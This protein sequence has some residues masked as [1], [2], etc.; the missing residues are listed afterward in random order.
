MA[1]Y[2][3]FQISNKPIDKEGCITPEDYEYG[4]VDGGYSDFMDYVDDELDD[5]ETEKAVGECQKLLEETFSSNGRE[6]TFLGADEFIEEWVLEMKKQLDE[7]DPKEPV[8]FWKLQKM[9]TQTHHCIFSRFVWSEVNDD[10]VCS[11]YPEEL[12]DFILMISKRLKPGDKVYIGGI[13]S[14]HY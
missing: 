4:L 3:I 5:D 9:T 8:S 11:C 10:G 2:K 13:V 1:H 12:G 7:I 6:L 14:F